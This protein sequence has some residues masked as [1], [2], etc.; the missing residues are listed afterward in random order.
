M[1]KTGYGQKRMGDFLF[2]CILVAMGAVIPALSAC[3]VAIRNP[4]HEVEGSFTRAQIYASE[5][6]PPP[7]EEEV[8]GLAPSPDHIWVGSYWTRHNNG[9]YWV[10]GRWAARPRPGAIWVDGRWEGHPRGYVRMRGYWR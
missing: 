2:P 3:Y 7:R 9:W 8:V 10:G 6:A 5:P 1:V 4:V